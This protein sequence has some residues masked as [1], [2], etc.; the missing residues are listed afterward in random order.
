MTIG[1]KEKK[2]FF[3]FEVFSQKSPNAHFVHQFSLLAPNHEVAMSMARENF[4]RR[5]PCVNLWVVK[6]DDIWVLPP[7]QRRYLEKLDNKSYR[8]TKGYGDLQSKW[9]RHK[10]RYEK[11]NASG[12]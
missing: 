6:R 2:D 5:E 12:K 3:V 1:D 8:E 7:E 11:K 9:R 4:L 10:E